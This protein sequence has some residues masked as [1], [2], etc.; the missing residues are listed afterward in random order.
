MLANPSFFGK[1][2][3]FLGTKVFPQKLAT[4]GAYNLDGESC[5]A[6]SR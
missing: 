4:S 5:R 1:K 6:A 2:V 3:K